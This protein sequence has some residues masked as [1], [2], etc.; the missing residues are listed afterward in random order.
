MIFWIVACVPISNFSIINLIIASW[1]PLEFL[2]LS[3]C[4]V[5]IRLEFHSSMI[6]SL[7]SFENVEKIFKNSLVRLLKKLTW[8]CFGVLKW[9]KKIQ[10]CTKGLVKIFYNKKFR[11]S[12]TKP[13]VH[14]RYDHHP[15]MVLGIIL[16]CPFFLSI[17]SFQFL[18]GLTY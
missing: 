12:N 15:S 13:C 18:F 2:E 3:A 10:A 9:K 6:S 4:L 1:K 5:F 16:F 11:F 17:Y 14:A 7:G 8:M